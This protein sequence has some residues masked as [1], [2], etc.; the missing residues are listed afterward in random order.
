MT[1][2]RPEANP[3]YQFASRTRR[4][5][6][7]DIDNGGI[8]SLTQW[9]PHVTMTMPSGFQVTMDRRGAGGKKKKK[10]KIKKEEKQK[11][12]RN[13]MTLKDRHMPCSLS[14]QGTSTCIDRYYICT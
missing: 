10:R 13:K 11:R 9:S 12:K 5:P 2:G 4:K 3:D 8:K 14:R 7:A 1:S 6:K